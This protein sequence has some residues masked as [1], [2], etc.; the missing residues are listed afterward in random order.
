VETIRCACGMA[1]SDARGLKKVGWMATDEG[2]AMH[3][4]N[5]T[6]CGSTI[7]IEVLA[8]ASICTTCH[9]LVTGCDGDP[10]SVYRDAVLCLSCTVRTILVPA[11][12]RYATPAQPPR[13]S[14]RGRQARAARK[15]TRRPRS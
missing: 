14:A 6:S 9:R 4:A 5:C 13:D 8:D 11:F 12:A 2:S 1:Y 15:P 3:L 7:T 10:K